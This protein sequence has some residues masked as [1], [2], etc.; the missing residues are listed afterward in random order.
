MCD[1]T[2]IIVVE[3]NIT[4]CNIKLQNI[5]DY[6]EIEYNRIGYRL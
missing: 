2:V 1:K 4:E 6:L 3:H 5:I